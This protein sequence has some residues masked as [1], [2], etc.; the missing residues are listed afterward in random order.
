M[1]I[2]YKWD[3][4]KALQLIAD[5]VMEEVLVTDTIPSPPEASAARITQITVGTLF[6]E[7]I[8]RIHKDLSLSALFS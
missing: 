2:M 6:A 4:G 1:V 8:I 5:S 7:A 3:A